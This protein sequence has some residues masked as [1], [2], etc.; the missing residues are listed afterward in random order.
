MGAPIA[1]RTVHLMN[2]ERVP[3]NADAVETAPARRSWWGRATG[4]FGSHPALSALVLLVV[5]AGGFVG[6]A[7]VRNLIDPPF[8]Q[9]SF[10]VPSAPKL[11][12]AAG[13]TVY[14]IDPTRSEARYDIEEKIADM[15][16]STAT[17]RTNGIA[18]DFAIS[19]SD[20]SA[21]RPGTIVINVEQFTSDSTLR[22]AR[23]RSDFLESHAHPLARF[24]PSGM[25]GLPASIETGRHYDVG[26][27]GDLTIKSTTRPVTWKAR[28]ALFGDRL[29][30]TANTT[31]NLSAFDVGPISIAGLV[32]TS[33]EAKL[34]L[35]LVAVDPT[36]QHVPTEIPNLQQVATSTAGPSFS[37]SVR[38]ILE[39]NCVGC[40]SKDSIGS[41]VW[42]LESAADASADAGGIALVTTNRYMPPWPP[43]HVGVP[44]QHDR[45]LSAH[46]IDLLSRWAKA[47]GQLDVDGATKLKARPTAEPAPPRRD[48]VLKMTKAY[49]GDG[50]K[51]NDYRC[52][53]LD[54]RFT[55]PT[56][57]TGT[58]FTPGTRQV[59]HHALIYRIPAADA[60]AT[61]QL[62]GKDGRPGWGCDA[63]GAMSAKDSLTQARPA[64][65]AGGGPK[66]STRALFAGWV[67]GQRPHSVG[68][69]TGFLFQPQDLMVVQIHYHYSDAVL[70]DRST[71]SLQTQAPTPEMRELKTTSPVAPVELP[72][73]QGATGPLCD[74]TAL[75][76]SQAK[77]Y[78]PTAP[79]IP[80]FL[81]AKCGADSVTSDPVTGNGTS[82]CDW[83]VRTTGHI[84]DVLGH[85]HNLGKTFRMTLN[86]GTERETVLLDIG[87]WSFDWQLNYQPVTAVPVQAGD[88]IRIECSWDRSQR[89]DPNPRYIAFAEGTEDEM[90]FST[91]TV[92]PDH[93]R[94]NG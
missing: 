28:V 13:E 53:I 5:F 93:P 78:G 44:M 43:S 92:D 75:L 21:S 73:P 19:Q 62:D 52:I 41:E 82:R 24:V 37:R 47:G 6:V 85:M 91:Y 26:I 65:G 80:T 64:D 39:E 48:L 35:K 81:L 31:V 67:P 32:S 22:D 94:G 60:E 12:P 38:P 42:K 71:L 14:R 79:L 11:V 29:E 3:S 50:T 61:R 55:S 72:C 66:G 83:R 30:A 36:K 70:P 4:V 34:S 7:K 57:V 2:D 87:S 77:E 88:T 8:Q 51:T 59:V 9:T 40:H 16:A 33:N 15:T 10:S 69:N 46:D 20:P 74:R 49:A 68:K 25:T 1:L 76:Q 58:E 89:Y 86:P 63:G 54:P 18:G 45:S 23:I 17:A 90:C 56:Y 84:V 27:A